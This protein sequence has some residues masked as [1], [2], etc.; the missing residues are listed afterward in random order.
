MEA[1]PAPA[2][3][4][5][6]AAADARQ[7]RASSEATNVG[8]QN[9]INRN[10]SMANPSGLG[11]GAP[12][13]NFLNTSVA[14]WVKRAMLAVWDAK[15]QYPLTWVGEYLI[16]CDIKYNNAP[17]TDAQKHFLYHPNGITS[18]AEEAANEASA[19][20]PVNTTATNG[21]VSDATS[22]AAQ[23]ISDPATTEVDIKD[24][25]PDPT[26]EQPESKVNGTS[27]NEDHEMGDAE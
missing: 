22:N 9:T 15:P 8:S 14:G 27:G 18:P 6:S 16:S 5:S 24:E 10:N 19:Q 25:N 11:A 4:A 26:T 12:V 17:A 23:D 20:A 3:A 13:R 2:F 7:S 21:H 1:S